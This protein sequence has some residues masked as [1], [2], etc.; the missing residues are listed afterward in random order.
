[1]V[2]IPKLRRTPE[3]FDRIL[4]QVVERLRFLQGEEVVEVGTIMVEVLSYFPGSATTA[5]VVT[6]NRRRHYLNAHPEVALHEPLVIRAALFPE[7][8]HID[9]Y[10]PDTYAHYV[11]LDERH[12]LRVLVRYSRRPDRQNS[13]ITAFVCR[14]RE[15]VSGRRRGLL[16]WEK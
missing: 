12:D 13:V 15:R 10:R 8:I 3:T 5:V 2:S 1:M 14:K 4:L 9:P 11:S 16:R 6:A 7:E